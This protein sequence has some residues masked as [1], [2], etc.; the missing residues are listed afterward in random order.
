M[1][2][3][4]LP[5]KRVGNDI[6]LT[7]QVLDNG[8]ALDWSSV[9][10]IYAS[11]QSDS[12]HVRMGLCVVEGPD[13]QDQTKL[14]LLYPAK[15]SQYAGVARLVLECNY[16]G[17]TST[18]DTPAFVFVPSTAEEGTG[19]VDVEISASVDPETNDLQILVADV[20]TSV[21]EE[22]ITDAQ[23][24]AAA[25]NHAADLATAAAG[26]NPY[27]GENNHWYVW[28]GQ[29][30][31]FVD[32][33]VSATGPKGDTGPAGPQGPKGDTGDTGAT[34]PKGDTG[35]AGPQGPKGD[36]GATGPQGPK[37][38][39]GATGPQGPKG[40]TGATGPQG[41]KGDT[42]DTGPQGATGATGATGPQGP[43]G[44]D[45]ASP[46]VGNNGNWFVYDDSTQ[47]YIDTGVHAQGPQGETGATGATGPQG[48]KGDT[49][50][51][52]PQGP[53]VP[54]STNVVSDKSDNTKAPSAKAVYDF[55]CPPKESSQPQG[56]LLSGVF[57]DLGTLTGNV[58]ILLA[59]PVDS[60]IA[61]EYRFTF[62]AGSTAPNITWPASV[63]LWGG[64]C[65]DNGAPSL[66]GGKTYEVSILDGRGIIIEF[67]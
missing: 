26:R 11:L 36:T 8:V 28:D 63:T 30:G 65:I 1:A 6:K 45:G 52:G 49:G 34:G 19:P 5:H 53:A 60:S 9:T 50:D 10:R 55:V 12:Q 66:T 25:A 43:A 39:T 31:E 42:G 20:D 41:P 48:P 3:V 56:G 38:D 54:L 24:A 23:E 62:V 51:T 57:Y 21:L 17:H 27:I 32:T 18:L 47:Q 29:A 22:A 15:S 40:D 33:G 61:N 13:S 14:R 58:T 44:R 7:V 37:G 4:N 64:N 67:E 46:Y 16:M 59:T 2:I 35:A